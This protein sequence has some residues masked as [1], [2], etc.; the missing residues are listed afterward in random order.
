MAVA[1][2]SVIPT[3]CW[4]IHLTKPQ[5]RIVKEAVAAAVSVADKTR[6][7]VLSAKFPHVFRTVST[8]FPQVFRTK[9]A[10]SL[11][12]PTTYTKFR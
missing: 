10:I 1:N 7:A 12:D 6:R 2:L 4:R 11:A 5:H 9:G 3:S 8:S